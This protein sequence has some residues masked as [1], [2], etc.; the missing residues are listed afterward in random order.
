MSPE[1]MSLRPFLPALLLMAIIAI[2]APHRA[3]AQTPTVTAQ[4][5]TV[6]LL[7]PPAQIAPGEN[8]TAGLDFKLETG[9]H[10]Y[11]INAG[12]SGEPPAAKWKLPTGVTADPLQFPAPTRLPLGPLM[13]FGYENEVV[14]PIP[15]HVSADFHPP[16]PKTTLAAHVTW[17]VCREVCIPGKADLA[18]VRTAWSKPAASPDVD[19][20]A[21]NL[22]AKFQ[23]QLPKPLPST[24]TATFTSTPKTFVLDVTTGSQQS[25]AQFFPLDETVIANAAP[26]PAQ[27]TANGVQLTLT[28]DENLQAPP[29]KLNGIA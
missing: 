13:D 29:Q 4:H 26:Q 22:I 20:A 27:S 6:S 12:D 15:M 2:A 8:F 7:V 17:L 23:A 10:V 25:S 28:K 24:D 18:V 14:F 1:T 3:V 5:L 9:W 19:A 11:W 16:S 21:Q